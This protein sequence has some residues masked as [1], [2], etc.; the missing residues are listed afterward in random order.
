MQSSLL[1]KMYYLPLSSSERAV[2]QFCNVYMMY[3][4]LKENNL[5][6]SNFLVVT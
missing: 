5:S 6:W 3:L 1:M 4:I 2:V